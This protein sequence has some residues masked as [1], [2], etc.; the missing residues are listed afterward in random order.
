MRTRGSEPTVVIPAED[1]GVGDAVKQVVD[2]GKRLVELEVELAT[3]ELKRKAAALGAGAVML[4]TALVLALYGLGF[5]LATISAALDLALPRWLGHLIVALVLLAVGG[6]LV[7]LG[8]RRMQKAT[9]PMPEAAL[10]EAKL[11]TEALK[12]DGRG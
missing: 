4:G 3:Y 5:V 9:P 8:L 11:T 2:H 6:L 7:L 10:R 12:G 1:V